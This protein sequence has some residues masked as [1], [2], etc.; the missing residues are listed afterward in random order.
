V[1]SFNVRSAACPSF[2]YVNIM[3]APSEANAIAAAL[4]IPREPPVIRHILP[5][6]SIFLNCDPNLHKFRI[7][8]FR[9][10][11]YVEIRLSGPD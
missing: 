3:F 4:P 11:F 2:L 7:T 6:K 1:S 5:L 10:D 8:V 9:F